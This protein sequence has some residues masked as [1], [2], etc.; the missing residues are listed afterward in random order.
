MCNQAI[1]EFE[2]SYYYVIELFY[3]PIKRCYYVV[4]SSDAHLS[5]VI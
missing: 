2:V 5:H 3:C 1:Q 4:I